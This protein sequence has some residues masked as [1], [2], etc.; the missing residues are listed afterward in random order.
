MN[1]DT[2]NATQRIAYN[3]DKLPLV[4]SNSSYFLQSLSLRYVDRRSHVSVY[5]TRSD[6]CI[7]AA[8]ETLV[9]LPI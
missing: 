1:D 9:E 5:L 7:K 3:P 6:S 8:Q 4:V 2:F